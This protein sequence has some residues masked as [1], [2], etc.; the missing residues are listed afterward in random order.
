MPSLSIRRLA[1]TTALS[2]SALTLVTTA[3]VAEE[4]AVAAA[5]VSDTDDQ[6]WG[7]FGIQTQ[8][9]D[10]AVDP[11]DDFDAY[12]NGRWNK[13]AVMPGDKTRMGAFI[14]LRDLSEERIHGILEE[15]T[16][17]QH[18][19]GSPEARISAAYKSFMDVDAINAS[20]LAPARPWL[21]AIKAAKTK[22][23]LMQLFA[24]PGFSSP[25]GAF[26]D[27]DEKKSDTYAM[28]IGQ[29]G[30]GLPDRDYY[31]VDNERNAKIR[32]QYLEYLTFLLGKA[33]YKDAKATAEAVYALETDLAKAT[34]DRAVQ[35]D[36][37]L[38]YNKLTAAELDALDSDSLMRTFV[39]TLGEGKVDAAIVAQM[40]PT[41]AELAAAKL[42]AEELGDK[43]GGGVP[44]TLKLIEGTPLATWQAYLTA[45]FLSDF[46]AYLPSDI[47]EANFAFYGTALRGQPEQRPRWKRGIA[48]VE[49]Q[50]G[51]LLGKIYEERYFP[52]ENQQAM[53]ELVGNLRKAMAANLTDLKWMGA[54]TRKEAEAK[55]NA[56]TPKIGGPEKFKTYDGLTIS[57]T[58]ALA[59]Q[60]A[61]Q[62]WDWDY[63]LARLGKDVDRSE[64]YMLPQTVNAYY[65]PVFNEVVFPAAILQPPFFNLTADPAVN[66]GAIG[67]VIG[68]EMGHGFDDQG[69]K[70]DGEGNLRD[71]WTPEDKAN[72][73]KLQDKLGAQYDQFCPFDEGKTCVNGK[74]TMGENIG[75]LGGLSLAYRAY[76]LSLGGKPAPV[77][78]GFTGDQRFFMAWAQ[79]WR[80]K[81]REEQARQF[82]I[83]DPH[84]PPEYRTNGTV[85]NFDEWYKAFGVK[86]GDKLY[87]PPEERVRIW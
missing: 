70:S 59:N 51:E 42:N 75:D 63:R 74:L 87:L 86:P 54:Q 15:L 81:V 78:D 47:D 77:I 55:L 34:W 24:K 9:V 83:T 65:N 85:R 28:Y 32:T 20:G 48:A 64:W 57:P 36:R 31:L 29:A 39:D 17:T 38:T 37:D 35:R 19:A 22:R 49:G 2:L 46:A 53:D 67:A 60:V 3:A 13:T 7:T 79:V 27:A 4:A 76:K 41:D 10:T 12:V 8:Y 40:P 73:E 68:H 23:D 14:M 43:L 58:N 80:S 25:L 16:A 6:D 71:W 82:L 11:G 45:H 66:Y 84:S 33:G 26:V 52:A 72:F 62:K 61:A 44:A 56:F 5:A 21:D 18:P 1:A 69:A 30:L 50:L